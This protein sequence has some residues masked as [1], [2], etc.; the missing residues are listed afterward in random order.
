MPQRRHQRKGSVCR[1]FSGATATS[2]TPQSSLLGPQLEVPAFYPHTAQH[3]SS[4]GHSSGPKSVD[5]SMTAPDVTAHG[6]PTNG[7]T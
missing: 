2:L 1:R 5:T 3:C 4:L 6:Q 7:A